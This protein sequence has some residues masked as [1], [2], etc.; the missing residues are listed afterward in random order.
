MSPRLKRGEPEQVE[1]LEALTQAFR[2]AAPIDRRSLF[3]G[4]TRQLGDLFGVADQ[5]GQHALVF[6]ERG[7]GK[8]SLVSVA[9]EVLGAAGVLTARTTCDRSDDFESVWK[10]VLGEVQFTVTR[11]AVGFAGQARDVR[12]AASALLADDASPHDVR[13]SLRSL[14]GG[15]R[16]AIFID[17]FD[18]LASNDDRLLF[19]DTIKSLSD[20]LP[21]ATIV[22][23]GVAD[24]V[25]QLIA[26][27]QSIERALV[28]IHMPRM[29]QGELAEIVTGGVERARLT[30]ARDAVDTIAR[31]AQGLPHYAHLL[32][33]LSARNALED[34]RTNVRLADVEDA[35][36]EAIEKTQQTVRET[37]RR[38]TE[39][40]GDGLFSKV[41]LAC[42]LAESD[43]YGFFTVADVRVPE[44]D[45]DAAA[46]L[47][48]LADPSHGS[49]LQ[50]RGAAKPRY[51]FVNPLLQPYVLMRGLAD[52]NVAA[53]LLPSS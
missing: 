15:R 17:E 19:A 38:A 12:V 13:R 8:T 51:R 20:E 34:L 5:P 21:D 44:E 11:P 47:D 25:E 22:L 10:K 23:V 14:S 6:G 24:D 43:E 3:S 27:H 39:E 46:Y 33:Q 28:Q 40:N 9:A 26:E 32:G 36:A 1:R 7:V 42:A 31:L 29:S 30:I 37:Y 48:A 52:G 53:E 4:R 2:P 50:R 35:V 16:V 41:V 45:L 49:L 18:R